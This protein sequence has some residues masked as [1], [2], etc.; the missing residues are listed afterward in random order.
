MLKLSVAAAA[1]AVSFESSSLVAAKP[2]GTIGSV[3]RQEVVASRDSG[4]ELVALYSDPAYI[5]PIYVL[6]LHG[7]TSYDQGIDAGVLMGKQMA[8]N[9]Q[10]LFYGLFGISKIEPLLQV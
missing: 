6:S 7:K 2:V 4:S 10:N 8:K 5:N 3:T 1:L 9:Y